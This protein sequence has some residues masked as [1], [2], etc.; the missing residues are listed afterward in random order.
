M[1]CMVDF[2]GM[3]FMEESHWIH[4]DLAARNLL[5]G[6]RQEVKICDFGHAV[7]TDDR[8]TPVK[9]RYPAAI[10]PRFRDY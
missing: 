10:L 2:A 8:N 3:C 9:V 7:Q 6:A 5:I 1:V 4:G